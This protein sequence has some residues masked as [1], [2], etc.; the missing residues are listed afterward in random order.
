[1]S[2]PVVLAPTP[3]LAEWFDAGAW[4]VHAKQNECGFMSTGVV[5][6]TGRCEIDIRKSPMPRFGSKLLRLTRTLLV[7]GETHPVGRVPMLSI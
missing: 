4:L 3:L 5:R 7:P 2:R 1:M 6:K